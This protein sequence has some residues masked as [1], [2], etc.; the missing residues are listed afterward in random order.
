MLK[1][2]SLL[3]KLRTASFIIIAIGG[4]FG[5]IT[6]NFKIGMFIIATGGFVAAFA[7]LLE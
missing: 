7:E 1:K 4:I 5:A 3:L 6:Q 2:G